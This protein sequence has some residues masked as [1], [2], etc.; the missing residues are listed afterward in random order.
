[1]WFMFM[2]NE[3]KNIVIIGGTSGIGL[4]TAKHLSETGYEVTVAGR[5][6]PESL[7]KIVY[8]YIDVTR[9]NSILD[10]FLGKQLDAIIYSA[11]VAAKKKP[12]QE[13]NVDEYLH[14]HNVNLL[15]AILTLKYAYPLLKRSK[16]KVVVVNSVAA[17]SHSKLSGFEYTI[18]KSGLCGLVKQL[19]VDWAVDGIAVNSVFPSMVETPMLKNNVDSE[20]LNTISSSIP[21]GCF[22]Q[23]EAVAKVIGFLVSSNSSYMT[24]AGIDING[25]KFLTG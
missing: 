21:F 5:T 17:R 8:Q 25:G 10:F 16:G 7:G 3:K 18:T 1:M 12:I 6:M 24:G 9:E 20:I 19:A 14:I 13:F 23:P 4:A 11:G 15:G 22:A 2:Q